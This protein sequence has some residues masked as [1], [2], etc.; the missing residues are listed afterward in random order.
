[1]EQI[2]PLLNNYPVLNMKELDELRILANRLGSS[3]GE[4]LYDK[5]KKTG[6]LEERDK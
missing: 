4:Y 5:R 1:M 2:K 6:C 3:L